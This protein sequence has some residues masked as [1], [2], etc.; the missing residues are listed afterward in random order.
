M[1]FDKVNIGSLLRVSAY[2][3]IGLHSAQYSFYHSLLSIILLSISLKYSIITVDLCTQHNTT[4]SGCLVCTL[5]CQTINTII[6]K[7]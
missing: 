5:M 7:Q 4:Q 2:V 6:Y 3:R 1:A